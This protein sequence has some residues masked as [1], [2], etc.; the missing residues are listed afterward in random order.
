MGFNPNYQP[1]IIV[2]GTTVA[3]ASNVLSFNAWHYFEIE[4]TVGASATINLYQ[5]GALIATY[6]GNTGSGNAGG[7]VLGQ[8]SNSYGG[9]G[10]GNVAFDDVYVAN[11]A[12]RQGERRVQ[13]LVP[14]ANS[15]V[16][17]TPLAGSNYANVNE[18]P[19]NGDTSYVYAST[20]GTQDL[21]TNS[22]LSGTATAISCVQMRTCARKD[23]SATRQIATVLSSTGTVQVGATQNV[24]TSYL[25][26]TDLYA[27]DPHTSAAWTQSGVNACL[28]GQKV[29]S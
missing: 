8:L 28:I 23:D 7:F 3:T 16:A 24:T 25:Y 13:T 5:D 4:A 17:W 15:S 12:T 18:L 1:I 27:T 26:Y 6:T 9:G 22:N 29:I 14:A 19:V 2:A 20:A 21:Y 10:P 11:T